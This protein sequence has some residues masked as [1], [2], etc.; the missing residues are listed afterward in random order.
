MTEMMA[1]GVKKVTEAVT[2][3]SNAKVDDLARDT[4]EYG[5]KDDRITTDWGVKQTNTDHW[6]GVVS[7][8]KQGPM[9]LE[10]AFAR[11]KI[12]RFDHERRQSLHLPIK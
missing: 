9:L 10:D 12:H 4:K 11:E 8:D 1:T 2:G 3:R 5:K 7:D 6:L